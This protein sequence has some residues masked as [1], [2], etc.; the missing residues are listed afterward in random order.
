MK[1]ISTLLNENSVNEARQIRYDV[2]LLG[3]CDNEGIPV[4][5]EIYIDK[6]YKKPFEK[7]LLEQQDNIFGHADGG[8]VEY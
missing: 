7:W 3:V 5:I 2:S 4:D 6:E 8:D 1:N